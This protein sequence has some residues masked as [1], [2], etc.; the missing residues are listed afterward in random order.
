M[1]SFIMQADAM[2]GCGMPRRGIMLNRKYHSCTIGSSYA[3][4]VLVD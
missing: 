3:I 4:L 1:I 2:R